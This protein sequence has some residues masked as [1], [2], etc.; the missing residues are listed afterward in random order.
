MNVAAHVDVKTTQRYGQFVAVRASQWLGR[1]AGR[2]GWHVLL[3]AL[4][5]YGAFLYVM[6]GSGKG[7]TAPN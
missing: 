6:C 5:S 2:L 3:I 4:L 1:P 7:C